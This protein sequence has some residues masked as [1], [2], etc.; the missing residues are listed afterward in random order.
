MAS[1]RRRGFILVLA[2]LLMVVLLLLAMGQLSAREAQYR[3]AIQAS[4][5]A[6]ALALAEAGLEDARVK[7]NRD[8]DFPPRGAE[9]QNLFC[10]SEVVLD[11]DDS[12]VVGRYDVTVD[13]RWAG[14]ETRVV[15]LSSVGIAGPVGTPLARRKLTIELDFSETIRGTTTLDPDLFRVLHREDEGAF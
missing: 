14:G 7:L 15:R 3:A 9:D 1:L 13:L 11:L 12:T 6:Q 5:G 10:Y 4:A 8:E 2:L